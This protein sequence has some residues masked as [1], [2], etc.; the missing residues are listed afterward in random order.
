MPDAN[1][2]RHR[3]GTRTRSPIMGL[4]PS[5]QVPT[6]GTAG[7]AAA[8]AG[9][10]SSSSPSPSSPLR[11]C[12]VRPAPVQ[13]DGIA[14]E[15]DDEAEDYALPKTDVSQPQVGASVLYEEDHCEEEADAWSTNSLLGPPTHSPLASPR[16]GSGSI[17]VADLLD[18]PP[19]LARARALPR[20]RPCGDED[21]PLNFGDSS[22]LMPGLGHGSA[23]R[24]FGLTAIPSPSSL[25]VVDTVLNASLYSSFY[26][27]NGVVS[28]HHLISASSYTHPP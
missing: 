20:P 7:T 4:F 5:R 3:E 12:H 9:V 22:H 13:T 27:S 19:P 11:Q 2:K 10:L 24:E 6:V 23:A 21:N 18:Q 25:C 16:N 8:G 28:I 1:S 26:S 17:V 14:E 15:T